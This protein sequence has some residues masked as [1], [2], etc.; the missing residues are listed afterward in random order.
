[1]G[2]KRLQKTLT[3]SE[4]RRLRVPPQF[5]H[6]YPGD[7]ECHIWPWASHLTMS[8]TFHLSMPP[9]PRLV[10]PPT[11]TRRLIWLVSAS[12]CF[13]VKAISHT[14]LCVPQLLLFSENPEARCSW[15]AWQYSP[16]TAALSHRKPEESYDWTLLGNKW[17]TVLSQESSVNRNPTRTLF[18]FPGP[19]NVTISLGPLP[20]HRT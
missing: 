12:Y 1:M 11:F 20:Y 3:T 2:R 10:K 16:P 19:S 13:V 7:C 8:I 6:D 9:I 17:A 18:H 14:S 4:M 15:P 5:L